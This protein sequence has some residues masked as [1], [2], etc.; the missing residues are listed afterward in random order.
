MKTTIAAIGAAQ[1]IC[2]PQPRTFVPCVSHP[3]LG[4]SGLTGACGGLHLK[5]PYKPSH[6]NRYNRVINWYGYC[7]VARGS[8]ER[9][10]G[11]SG[12]QSSAHTGLARQDPS[13]LCHALQRNEGDCVDNSTARH[14]QASLYAYTRLAAPAELLHFAFDSVLLAAAAACCHLMA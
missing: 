13:V 9:L 11:C 14:G 4:P 6:L 12:V 7:R 5:L 10:L 8:E 1:Q 3:H 2:K